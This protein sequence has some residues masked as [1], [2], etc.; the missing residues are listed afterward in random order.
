MV[1][2]PTASNII[3]VH[4]WH[5]GYFVD[6]PRYDYVEGVCQSFEGWDVDQLN[7]IE[8]G[9]LV[10]SLGYASFKCVWYRNPRLGLYN[11]IKPFKDD[12]DVIG[13]LRDVEGH[14]EV[15]FYV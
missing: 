5:K 3:T 1:C 9:K 11:G 13:F 6:E 2:R 15:E 7:S 14:D 4:L 10:K 8:I 12:A